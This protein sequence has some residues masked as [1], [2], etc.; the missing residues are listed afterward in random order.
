MEQHPE[1]QRAIA[2]GVMM[3]DFLNSELGMYFKARADME[4]EEAMQKLKVIPATDVDGIRELQ[5][6]IARHES[7]EQWAIDLIEDGEQTY[8][9]Y[10]LATTEG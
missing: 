4:I 7:F 9:E 6:I 5:N 10:V 8:Q 3:Q 2:L 1:D